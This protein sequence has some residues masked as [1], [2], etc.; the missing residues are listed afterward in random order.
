[1]KT[2]LLSTWAL[3]FGHAIV[4]LSIGLQGPLLAVRAFD[5]DF[6]TSNTGLI[7]AGL[8]AGYLAGALMTPRM[9]AAI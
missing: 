3:F 4:T 8:F 2:V 9:T 7:M 1:M 5:E 6:D